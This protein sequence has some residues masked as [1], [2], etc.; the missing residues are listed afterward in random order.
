MA[1]ALGAAAAA[2]VARD[3]PRQMGAKAKGERLARMQASPQ[4]AAGRFHN[5]VPST[6][7]A[8]SSMP[9]IFAA[10]L[11]DR[12]NRH[13]HQPIPLVTPDPGASADGLHITWYGH[14]SALVEIEGKRVL[15]DPVWSERCS[16]SQLSGPKRLHEP[17][18]ARRW[19]QC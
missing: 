15:L 6:Q 3:I 12:E 10:T 4:Y 2:W 19:T 11:R 16:P 7:L 9:R 17:P 1:L 18:V 13:P 8:A 5:S 14:S